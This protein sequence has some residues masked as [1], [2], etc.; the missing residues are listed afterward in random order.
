MT[1]SDS[2][3]ATARAAGGATVP[4]TAARLGLEPHPEGGWYRRTWASPA[5]V[6]TAGGPRPAAT[7]IH[8]LLEPGQ[9]SAWHVVSSD[10]LWL[11][12]GPGTLTL[13]LGG[14]GDAPVAG[15]TVLLGAPYD[16]EAGAPALAQVLIPAGVWQRTHPAEHEVLV[17]CLVSPG[18]SFDDW[19]LAE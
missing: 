3:P 6:E 18:F 4:A 7:L 11:W 16:V 10:E 5:G 8:Y 1:A 19:R 2:T 14:S 17:S 15:E 9:H 12:H 13:Q